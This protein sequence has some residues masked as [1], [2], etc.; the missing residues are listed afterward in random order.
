MQHIDYYVI[1]VIQDITLQL[2]AKVKYKTTGR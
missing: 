2:I 1:S